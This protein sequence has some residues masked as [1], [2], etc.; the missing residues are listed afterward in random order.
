MPADLLIRNLR[1]VD[2][3]GEYGLADLLIEDGFIASLEGGAAHETRDA[4]GWM[5]TPGLCDP[6]A[7]LR[8]PGQEAKEDLASG[9]LA[10][11]RGGYTDLV[12]MPNTSPPIDTPAAVEYLLRK[13]AQLDLARLHP[14]AA[15]SQNQAGQLLTEAHALAQSGAIMLTDDGQT[16]ED[17]G[18]LA[19]GLRYAAAWKL[20]VAVHAE[21]ASLRRNGVMNEGPLSVQLG[22][23]GNPAAAEAARVARD[24]EVLRQ[25]M[26][27][28]PHHLPRLHIQ[29]LSTARALE[30]ITLARQQGLPV[31]TEV[32]PHHLTLTDQALSSLDPVYKVAPPLRT[33]QDVEALTQ[34]LLDGRIDCVATDH[35]PHTRAEKD[36]DMLRAPSGIASLEVAWALLFTRLH[37]EQGFPLPTLVERFTDGPRRILGLPPIRLA[38]GQ[39]ASLMLFDPTTPRPVNSAEFATKARFGPWEG[40]ELR[41]WPQA[42]LVR[43]RVVFGQ[44]NPGAI[45]RG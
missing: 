40:W 25:A 15:L 13:A 19:L 45:T 8:D 16:N 10:A 11:V 3:R 44:P 23:P 20:V 17:A 18:L 14:S 5:A 39:E 43:G 36:L 2:G 30:L 38:V 35:A 12:S 27:W 6:H 4:Q 28:S 42:T 24:L 32:C 31:T 7:H 33:A 41:G 34:G 22:L 26:E 37:L 29:H 1:L 9:L 21:D